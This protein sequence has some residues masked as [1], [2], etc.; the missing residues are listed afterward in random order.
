MNSLLML[1]L[2]NFRKNIKT[3]LPFT[4]TVIFSVVIFYNL[5]NLLFAESTRPGSL[6][7][8]IL[9]VGSIIIYLFCI[10]FLFYTNSFLIKSRKREFGIYNALGLE[11]KHLGFIVLIENFIIFAFSIAIGLLLGITFSK[12][13]ILSLSKLVHFNLGYQFAI[14]TQAIFLTI[15][16][17]IAIYAVITF[18]N[19]KL[20]YHTKTIEMLKANRTGEVLS[21]NHIIL[22]LLSLI[23]LGYGYFKALTIVNPMKAI[24][25]FALAVCFVIAGTYLA[26]IALFNFLL[27]ILKHKSSIYYQPQNFISIS[28]L[29]YRIKNSAVG[30]ASITVLSTGTIILLACTV[31]LYSGIT[32]AVD[33][34][35]P[36]DVKITLTTNDSLNFNTQNFVDDLKNNFHAD[37]LVQLNYM[38]TFTDDNFQTFYNKSFSPNYLVIIDESSYKAYTKEEFTLKNH[39]VLFHSFDDYN[40]DTFEIL[41][42]TFNIVGTSEKLYSRFAFFMTYNQKYLVVSDE[43]YNVLKTIDV[44]KNNSD[45]NYEIMFDNANLSSTDLNAFLSEYKGQFLSKEVIVKSEQLSAY[46]EIFGTFLFLGIFIGSMLLIAIVLTIFYKQIAEG[47]EDRKTFQIL[48]LVGVDNQLIHKSINKQILIVFLLPIIFSI[49][50]IIF[51]FKPLYIILKLLYLNNINLI[52]GYFIGTIAVFFIVYCIVYKITSKIYYQIC[53]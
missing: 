20:I 15:I 32:N 29:I 9:I 27:K 16:G 26:F 25:E 39:E 45:I 2:N 40:Q 46:Y 8:R 43:I 12:V 14:S 50:H 49:I 4:I 22:A 21:K 11:K 31:S 41:G 13:M 52:I 10:I 1:S 37:N 34:A 44:L 35:T 28:N 23:C 19:I 42:E 18:S 47:Y 24:G 6:M 30:L 5:L 48:K 38:T 36:S 7:F 53:A 3:I 17:F 51:A 33:N